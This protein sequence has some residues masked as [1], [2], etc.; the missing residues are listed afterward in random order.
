M[1]SAIVKSHS[2]FISHGISGVMLIVSIPELCPLS[3][4]PYVFNRETIKSKELNV[5]EQ[6]SCLLTHRQFELKET[7][8]SASKGPSKDSLVQENIIIHHECKGW[9]EKY[10]SRITDWH[11]EACRVMTNGDPEGRIFL[12]HPHTNNGLFFL[13]TIKYCILC[14]EKFLNTMRC[15][16][17]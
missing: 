1:D 2:F 7:T 6:S 14:S 8:R 13:L 17:T 16:I 9:I 3:Y 5:L 15:D 10:V 12:S 4:F 11:H